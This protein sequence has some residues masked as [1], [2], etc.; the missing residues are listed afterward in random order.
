M[1]FHILFEKLGIQ[2]RIKGSS[3][4]S[5]SKKSMAHAWNIYHSSL[6]TKGSP[7][8]LSLDKVASLR[9]EWTAKNAQVI[10]SSWVKRCLKVG[11]LLRV[12]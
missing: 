3:E 6:D 12:T 5:S 8:A 7:K 9:I 2:K 4:M 1:P 11:V 10:T